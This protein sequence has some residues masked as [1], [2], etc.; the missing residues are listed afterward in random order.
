MTESM[1]VCR[2]IVM[3]REPRLLHWISSQHRKGLASAFET[4][5]FT[6]SD[7]T[8]YKPMEAIVVQTTMLPLGNAMHPYH[9]THDTNH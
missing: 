6:S 4:S 3:E 2:Q 5:K 9:L 1:A 7:A 8:P